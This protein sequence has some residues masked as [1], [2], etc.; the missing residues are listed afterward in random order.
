MVPLMTTPSKIS[1]PYITRF[2]PSPSGRLHLGH[3]YSALTAYRAAKQNGGRFL[4]RIEDIDASRCKPEFTDGIFEDLAWLGLKWETPV[5]LQSEHMDDYQQALETLKDRG[6]LYPCFCTRKDIR[7]KINHTQGISGTPHHSAPERG[8]T[9]LIYPGTCRTLS[10]T[11][12]AALIQK[13]TPHAWRLNLS[14]ALAQIKS[15]APNETELTWF[16]EVKGKIMTEP[17]LLGDVILGRKEMPTSYH[18]SVVIDD[19]LQNISHIVRGMDLFEATHIHI[20]L[21]RLL[22][23]P[24]PV[25]HHHALL[26]D[27]TGE[28]FA[29]SSRSATLL[30]MRRSGISREQIISNIGLSEG[31]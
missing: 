23:L 14:A 4:L 26:L 7:A 11:K 22:G 12:A 13:D 3:A 9:G 28:R 30:S 19:A 8:T 10:P 5:R 6:L 2:A 24:T 17:H 15:K 20:I 21:Q 27:D 1:Q 25:Y 29:K 16:D 31:P 18:L